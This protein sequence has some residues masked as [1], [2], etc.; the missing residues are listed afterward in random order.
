MKK[1]E[2][3]GNIL[4]R[5][6]LKNSE[7]KKITGGSVTDPNNE[8]CC[9]LN[10]SGYCPHNLNTSDKC[11]GT[12][13]CPSGDSCCNAKSNARGTCCNTSG[14]AENGQCNG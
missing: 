8:Q 12:G 1:H 7:L 4:S 3:L 5:R 14:P 2:K 9:G 11:C 10:S 6:T 13:D